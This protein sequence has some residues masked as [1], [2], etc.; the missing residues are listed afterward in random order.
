[1]GYGGGNLNSVKRNNDCKLRLTELR[2]PPPHPSL[3]ERPPQGV[4]SYDQI[5]LD[6]VGCL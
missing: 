4:L 2:F 1:M 5:E 3:K 6:V